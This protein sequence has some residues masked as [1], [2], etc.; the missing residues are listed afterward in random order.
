MFLGVDGRIGRAP[1]WIGNALLAGLWLGACG[2]GWIM[3]TYGGIG[4][5][6]GGQLIVGTFFLAALASLCLHV[7]RLHD[8]DRSGWWM[9][10]A[11]IPVLG[12]VMLLVMCGGL[13]GNR[14]HNRFGPRRD[15]IEPDI[16]VNPACFSP[17]QEP[18]L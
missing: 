17:E 16:L 3:L 2:I 14:C 18:I 8:L 11:A 6:I 10:L 5:L 15:A 12:I 4:L 9:L 7:R 1:Y 13:P